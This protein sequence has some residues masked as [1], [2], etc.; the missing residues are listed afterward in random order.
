MNKIELNKEIESAIHAQIAQGIL[1]GLDS[2]DRDELLKKSVV[3]VIKDWRFTAAI[4]EVAATQARKI[5]KELMSEPAWIDRV[6][7]TIIEAQ[8]EY[9]IQLREAAV[10]AM[11][12][13]FHGSGGDSYNR[14]PG[15]ILKVW[16]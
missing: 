13:A 7:A 12:Q 14:L 1:D 10:K 11:K 2:K 4:S 3:D 15:S 6:K 8:D 5:A 9:L 16:P